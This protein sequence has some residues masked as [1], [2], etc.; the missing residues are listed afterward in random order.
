MRG[1]SDVLG[2]LGGRLRAGNMLELAP[3]CHRDWSRG[4]RAYID[5]ISMVC[6]SATRLEL[7]CH[8]SDEGDPWCVICDRAS[9]AVVVHLARIDRKYVI[10]LPVQ[11]W[12]KTRSTMA[13]VVDI[14]LAEIAQFKAA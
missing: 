5:R 7:E 2:S 11:A 4:E 12:S 3:D 14:A 9:G 8:F 10:V 6:R 13:G 1:C